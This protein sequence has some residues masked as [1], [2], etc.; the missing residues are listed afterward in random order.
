LVY[1]YWRPANYNV[2]EEFLKHE[3]EV[4]EFKDDL[5]KQK[6]IRFIAI[7]YPEFWGKYES[8]VL[9]RKHISSMK[10]RY[11]FNI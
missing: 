4:K 1:I 9:F 11:S 3:Q 10:E 5:K 6:D 7:S 8:N 2:I